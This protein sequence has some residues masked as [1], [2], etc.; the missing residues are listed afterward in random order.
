MP[1]R[2]LE[3]EVMHEGRGGDAL[4]SYGFLCKI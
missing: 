3:W 1:M 2:L 4:F